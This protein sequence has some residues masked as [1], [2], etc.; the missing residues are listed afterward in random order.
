MELIEFIVPKLKA[1]DYDATFKDEDTGKSK[2]TY[3]VAQPEK[4][5]K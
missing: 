4:A 2:I 1:I 3:T 5:N